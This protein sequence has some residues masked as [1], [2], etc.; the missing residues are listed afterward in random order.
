MNSNK[1]LKRKSCT[2][3]QT[4]KQSLRLQKRFSEWWSHSACPDQLW[5]NNIH[6]LFD[7]ATFTAISSYNH[8]P[9]SSQPQP[10]QPY[11]VLDI[12]CNKGYTSADFLDALSPG[13]NVNPH[14]LVTAIRAIASEDNTKIDRDGGV[15]NDSKKALNVDRTTVREVEVH[16]FEPSPATFGML[17]RAHD[18]LMP[19]PSSSSSSSNGGGG[20]GAK[21]IIHNKGLHNH[22]GKMSWHKACANTIGDELC[23]I[24]DDNTPDAITIPVIT[25]DKFLSE[26]YPPNNNNPK[27]LVHMLKIDAEGLDPA[28]L[29]GAMELLTENRAIMVVFEFNPRLSEKGDHPHGMWGKGGKPQVTLIEVTNWLDSLGY[30]CY[31][32]TLLVDET[33]KTKGG[34]E[35]APGLYRITGGCI[36]KEPSVRGWA[37]VVCASRRYGNVAGRLLELASIVNE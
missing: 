10:S 13:T 35:E 24:V 8:H 11:L 5:M 3:T 31:L 28:V 21:W 15:C 30:D 33:E 17:Q 16:C 12:G 26:T 23:T 27:P 14:T 37:N 36:A 19:S 4:T 34:V 25:V 29:T 6:T 18:K 20:G 1:E 9:Q 7:D 2:A 32:D 22:N